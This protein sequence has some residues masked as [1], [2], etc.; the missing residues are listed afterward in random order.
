MDLITMQDAHAALQ[1]LADALEAK[2]KASNQ[3]E[4]DIASDDLTEAIGDVERNAAAAAELL[5]Q[6]PL[7]AS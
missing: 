2:A 1:R 3:D 5:R 4:D 7:A 6:L